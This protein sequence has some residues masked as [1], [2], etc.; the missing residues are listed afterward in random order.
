MEWWKEKIQD[1][2]DRDN[3]KTEI[4][5]SNGYTVLRFWEH[6]FRGNG[7]EVAARVIAKAVRA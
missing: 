5:A 7:V 2:I 4:L 1:N 3:K 6:D